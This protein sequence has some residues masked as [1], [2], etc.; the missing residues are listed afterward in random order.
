MNLGNT[1]YLNAT[2]QV[3]RMVPELSTALA[4]SPA[5]IG[6]SGDAGLTAALRDL[7]CDLGNTRD[8]VPPIVFLT[9]LRQIAPQFAERGESGGFAQQDAEEV[10]VRILN[11]LSALPAPGGRLIEQ[12]MTGAMTTARKCTE[13]TDEAP[14]NASEPFLMLHCNISGTTNEMT[15]GIREVCTY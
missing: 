3:L 5:R 13:M 8:A 12:Y 1:C 10:Y 11:S 4:E 14:T 6:S 9:V 15:A 2:V 7:F